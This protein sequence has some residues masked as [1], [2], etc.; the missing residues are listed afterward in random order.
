MGIDNSFYVYRQE[1]DAEVSDNVSNLALNTSTE[2]YKLARETLDSQER[3]SNE[4]Y[5]LGR[6]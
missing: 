4:V 2:A 3:M 6:K 1:E 5:D